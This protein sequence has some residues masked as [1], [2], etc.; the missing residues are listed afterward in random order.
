MLIFISSTW[1]LRIKSLNFSG[2][3]AATSKWPAMNSQKDLSLRAGGAVSLQPCTSFCS[4]PSKRACSAHQQVGP[5]DMVDPSSQQTIIQTTEPTADRNKVPQQA[6][7]VCVL[8]LVY[9]PRQSHLYWHQ[10]DQVF[11]IYMNE[12]MLKAY[13]C[14]CT[15]CVDG[16]WSYFTAG[17]LFRKKILKKK[18]ALLNTKSALSVLAQEMLLLLPKGL[19]FL[20]QTAGILIPQ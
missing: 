11:F 3:A 8:P 20:V 9:S 4:C 5:S 6:I 13:F 18:K 7:F 2:I 14:I 1:R 10:T 19:I 15:S 16:I 17:N 12:K